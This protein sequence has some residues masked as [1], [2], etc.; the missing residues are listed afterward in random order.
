[1]SEGVSLSII[2]TIG[3]KY[4]IPMTFCTKVIVNGL[5]NNVSFLSE[6]E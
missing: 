5:Y 2:N 3:M 1:M 4:I 6:M